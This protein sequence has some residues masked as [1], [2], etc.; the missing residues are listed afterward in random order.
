LAIQ[1][2][3]DGH[4][5]L[6]HVAK[7]L[8][9]SPATMRRRMKEP[10]FPPEALPVVQRGRKLFSP[11]AIQAFAEYNDRAY[12]MGP[13]NAGPVP[14]GRAN[15]EPKSKTWRRHHRM[16]QHRFVTTPHHPAREDPDDS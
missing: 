2:R 12:P 7:I 6:G 16:A 11:E 10:D 4:K 5:I 3:Q 9:I 15:P 1:A 14:D 13:P 8:G